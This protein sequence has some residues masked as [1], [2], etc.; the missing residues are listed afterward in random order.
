MHMYENIIR[1]QK[2]EIEQQ[3]IR[4]KIIQREIIIKPE[5]GLANLITGIRRCGK[6]TLAHLL[7]K[8][9]NYG[10]INFDDEILQN[11][12]KEDFRILLSDIISVCGDIDSIIL[13]EP[14]NIEGWELFVNRLLRRN[15]IVIITGSN[16]KLLSAEMGT[17]LTGRFIS[18][19]LYPFGFKEFLKYKNEELTGYT[20]EMSGKAKKLLFSYVKLGGFPEALKISD[21]T[22][23]LKDLFS[24]LLTKDIARRHEIR[25]FNILEKLANYL[26]SIPSSYVTYSSLAKTFEISTHS[27]ISYLSYFEEAYLFFFLPIFSRKYKTQIRSP[28]KIY[29]ADVGLVSQIGFRTE[30][31]ITRL[32]ENLVFLELKRRSNSTTEIY[33]WKS[34]EG[35]EVDF[36][37]KDG[38][39]IQQLI[40]V[41]YK[42]K[43][44]KT[45][46][47]EEKGLIKAS[48]ELNCHNLI[49]LTWDEE[50][51]IER[52]GFI[53][54][55]KTLWKWLLY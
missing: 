23:Y 43:N 45:R 41:C 42:M 37:I 2:R 17:H 4:E 50:K 26:L 12:K 38:I 13:D 6:S 36:I 47:R 40:Q 24:S 35:Y 28:K 25:K 10:Y 9:S 46:K 21:S 14:Q 3:F 55:Y 7:L 39:E 31:N 54:D 44:E 30:T 32:I 27:I 34:P 22:R 33:Y 49:L 48:K 11:L 52:E 20:E 1:D 8:S 15:L 16:S 18:Y 53:I 29:V 51:K 19:V 5:Q